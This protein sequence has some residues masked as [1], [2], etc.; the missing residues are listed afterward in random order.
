MHS[1]TFEFFLKN[2][3]ENRELV[4]FTNTCV[5]GVGDNFFTSSLRIESFS[6]TIEPLRSG[7]KT[8]SFPL[9]DKFFHFLPEPL[10][11]GG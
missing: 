6:K 9:R 2:G 10:R 11:R 3:R 7:V 5:E 4:V 8:L 1:T